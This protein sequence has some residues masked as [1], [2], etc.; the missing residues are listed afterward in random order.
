MTLY[1]FLKEM[2]V[3]SYP[4][5][6]A[7][8]VLLN[9]T[10]SLYMEVPV[11]QKLPPYKSR[12]EFPAHIVAQDSTLADKTVICVAPYVNRKKGSRPELMVY[13]KMDKKELEPLCRQ[14]D[15]GALP[16]R[17]WNA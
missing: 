13:I 11:S 5:T 12:L 3:T 10:T 2:T 17:Y 9:E 15:S 6:A 8:D 16:G 4:V 1:Q 14:I 7:A